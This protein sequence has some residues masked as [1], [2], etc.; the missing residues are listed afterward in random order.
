MK[1]KDAHNDKAVAKRAARGKTAIVFRSKVSIHEWLP[2]DDH[3]MCVAYAEWI[4][5]MLDDKDDVRH[6]ESR[7]SS[8][9][10]SAR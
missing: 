7:T 1:K 10:S 9:C 5:S 8:A 3:E 6:E 2:D 4:N